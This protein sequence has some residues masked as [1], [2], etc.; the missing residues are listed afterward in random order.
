MMGLLVLK[1]Q[2]K[3]FYA[4]Y[5]PLVNAAARFVVA[6]AACYMII[7]NAG[8]MPKLNSPVVALLL[9]LLC[10]FLPYGAIAVL[11]GC[12]LL[13]QLYAASLEIAVITFAF[14][15]IVVLLYYGFQPGDSILLVVTPVL[16]FLKVPF[17]VSLLVGLAGGLVS[18]IPM[19]CG[20]FLYYVILYVKQNS[21]FL[22]GSEQAEMTQII[23][24]VVKSLLGNQT[25]MVMIAACC[26]G[27]FTV[28]MVKKL[29][30]N[31]AWAV[32]IMAG[33][34]VQMV[35]IFLGDFKFDVAFSVPELMFATLVSSAVAAVYHFFVFTV[36]YSRTEYVQ[37]EDDDYYYYVKAVPKIAVSAPEIKVQKITTR[38]AVKR[39][40]LKE[41]ELKKKN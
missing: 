38:K 1:E 18:V 31:Y 25:M 12:F 6:F 34:V 15:L 8:F 3:A 14:L 11:T 5:S 19:S 41:A 26:L 36:D 2:L 10:A 21:S 4:K 35:V 13:V 28:H 16:F 33:T 7:K 9:G 29:S 40:Q 39:P 20:I 17:A 22:A 30:M 32:A 27:A 23:S 37:F 24:Q